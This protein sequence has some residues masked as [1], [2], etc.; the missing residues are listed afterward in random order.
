MAGASRRLVLA[1]F[2]ALGASAAFQTRL[3][4]QGAKPA[5]PERVALNGYDPVAYFTDGRPAKGS[6]EF[7]ASF[8]GTTYHF[9]NAQHRALF[10]ADPDRY[11]PQ[12]KAY[13]AITI[14]RGAKQEVDPEAFLI[15]NGKLYMFAGKPGVDMFKQEAAAIVAKAESAWPE[16]NKHP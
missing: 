3:A 4:A 1:A 6:G 14:A 12:Y 15:W 2:S 13:C 16:V 5:S 10:V 9:K 11:A 7:S 8:D